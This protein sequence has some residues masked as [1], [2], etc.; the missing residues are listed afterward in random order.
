MA[1]ENDFAISL[2]TSLPSSVV[3]DS[4]LLS[5]PELSPPSSCASSTDGSENSFFSALS[6]NNSEPLRLP[7][8]IRK[9]TDPVAIVVNSPTPE[10]VVFPSKS[11][12]GRRP[13]PLPLNDSTALPSTPTSRRPRKLRKSRPAVPKLSLDSI[14]P[15]DSTSSQSTPSPTPLSRRQKPLLTSPIIPRRPSSP[16][17]EFL[18]RNRRSSLPTIPSATYF[19]ATKWN[20]DESHEESGEHSRAVRFITPLGSNSKPL[21]GP[22]SPH[23]NTLTRNASTHALVSLAWTG[24]IP[25]SI[26]SSYFALSSVGSNFTHPTPGGSSLGSA[27]RSTWSDED[28]DTCGNSPISSRPQNRRSS[29]VGR[30]RRWTLA[31]AITNDEISDEMF[32]DEVERMRTRGKFWEARKSLDSPS[33]PRSPSDLFTD[34]STISTLPPQLRRA[35]PCLSDPLLS[36]TW[37]TARRVL[38]ICREFIRTERNYLASMFLLVSNGTAT[39][40]PVLMLTYVPAL[41]QA[42][43]D[44]L[45]RMEANPSAQGVAEAFLEGELVLEAAFVAWCGVGGGFFVGADSQAVRDRAASTGVL[46]QT[47]SPITM[48][49]KRRVT[50][51]V[52]RNSSIKS[53]E[54]T[55]IL[56]S[57][58]RDPPGA[59]R[60]LP[61]VRDL[62]ILPV[63]R[64][65]R[66]TLLFKDLLAHTP[67]SSPSH[68]VVERA[69]RVAIVIAQKSDRAQGN[70]AFLRQAV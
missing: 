56:P 12:G 65:M 69:M 43:E 13:S 68:A 8:G 47:D 27:R 39:P 58:R 51:W 2:Q 45:L 37:Q 66:Y 26:G 41:V 6:S 28:E 30:T 34:S 25:S 55:A 61:S 21:H 22:R 23:P 53:R 70:A 44:L 59:G 9:S 16:E 48:P 62:A 18:K 38:L 31:M 5:T 67:S 54:R 1:M 33:S 60:S 36:A 49:L 57:G 14:H 19:P 40:A 35:L 3:S 32:V 29:A 24:Q 10:R 20:S 46:T 11:F 64:V 52:K 42:S 63:Q 7:G 17:R 4:S 15:S 50:T